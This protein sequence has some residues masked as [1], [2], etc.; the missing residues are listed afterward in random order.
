MRNCLVKRLPMRLRGSPRHARRYRYPSVAPEGAE[1]RLRRPRS[2]GTRSSSCWLWMHGAKPR[3][4]DTPSHGLRRAFVSDPHRV[5]PRPAIHRGVCRR[6]Q[7]C[8][9]RIHGGQAPSGRMLGHEHGSG[10]DARSVDGAEVVGSRHCRRARCKSSRS[11]SV[12]FRGEHRARHGTPCR[13]G[14]RG[15]APT[16]HRADRRL[17]ARNDARQCSAGSTHPWSRACRAS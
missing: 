10:H 3:C 7:E 9:N 15:C 16:P 17:G 14:K 11:H 2:G 8:Q 6:R 4:P 12:G 1:R 5:R 13:L